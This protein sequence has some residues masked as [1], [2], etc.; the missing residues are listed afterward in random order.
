[1]TFQPGKS[2]NPGGKAKR[3]SIMTEALMVALLRPHENDPAGRSKAAVAAEE[4]VELAIKGDVPAWREIINRIEGMPSQQV[5]HTGADGGPIEQVIRDAPGNLA[6]FI[7]RL[8][9]RAGPPATPQ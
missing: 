5:Q 2:G 7:A 4:L 8:I 9:E 3:P 6:R 1:M